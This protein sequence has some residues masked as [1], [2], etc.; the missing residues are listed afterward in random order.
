MKAGSFYYD[1]GT[2]SNELDTERNCIGICVIPP[3]FLPDRKARIMSLREMNT[4]Y[5]EESSL[6]GNPMYWGQNEVDTAVPNSEFFTFVSKNA[7]DSYNEKTAY[8]KL[9]LTT[10]PLPS[11]KEYNG[12]GIKPKFENKVDKGTNWFYSSD[13]YCLPSPYMVVNGR[14]VLCPQYNSGAMSDFNGKGN[15]E[16]LANLHTAEDW[17]NGDLSEITNDT[18]STFA[19]AAVCCMKYYT[20]GTEIGNWYLP[21]IGELGFVAARFKEIQGSLLKLQEEECGV[22]LKDSGLEIGNNTNVYPYYMT[23]S[24][25]DRE[26]FF[27]FDFLDFTCFTQDKKLANTMLEH[28]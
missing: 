5:I 25:Y 26:R 11:N 16:I 15:T 21:S 10:L 4:G 27:C 13:N 17:K 2:Y 18:G 28:L 20:D 23:S 24:E 6:E 8:N 14:E 1:D 19:P 22:P 9:V 3:N 7:I 12:S